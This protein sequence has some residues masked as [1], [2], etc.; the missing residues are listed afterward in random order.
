MSDWLGPPPASL[1]SPAA[2]RLAERAGITRVADVTALDRIGVPVVMVIRPASR[3]FVV[4][5]GKGLTREAAALSGL[6]ES[7]EGFCAETPRG[8]FLYR[9]PEEMAADRRCVDVRALPRA[10]RQRVQPGERLFWMEGRSLRD[11]AA[12]R[13]PLESVHTDYVVPSG[14]VPG[15]VLVSSTGLGAGFDRDAAVLHALCE[16]IERDAFSL[17]AAAHRWTDPARKLDLDIADTGAAGALLAKLS[18]AE[19]AT[20]GWDMTSDIG[21]PCVCVTLDRPSRPKRKLPALDERRRLPSRSWARA[22]LGAA[23]SH[24]VARD[25]D[26]RVARRSSTRR[27]SQRRN[28]PSRAA[29]LGRRSGPGPLVRRGGSGGERRDAEQR[30]GAAGGERL[31]RGG[32]SSSR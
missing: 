13:T 8:P 5:Q 1:L 31:S 17:F 2:A 27:L 11:G 9:S 26:R 7:L 28:R 4:S 21:V 16:V 10:R 29:G 19:I 14:V 25:G 20:H 15:H 24:P 23:R 6:M 12:V 18:R 30:A 3:S 32:G 22:G